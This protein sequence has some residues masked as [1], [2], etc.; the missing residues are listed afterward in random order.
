MF[1]SCNFQNKLENIKISYILSQQKPLITI[2][3][4]ICNPELPTL[5]FFFLEETVFLLDFAA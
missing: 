2:M 5:E 1:L 3:F 4:L